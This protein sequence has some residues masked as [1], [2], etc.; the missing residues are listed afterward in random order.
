[1]NFVKLPT[2]YK[3]LEYIESNGTQWIN[4]GIVP[5]KNTKVIMDFQL[6]N[7]DSTN[8]CI[9]GVPGQYS[10]RWYGPSS[11]FRANGSNSKNFPTSIDSN[12]RHIVEQTGTTS[13]I[14]NTYSVTI[15]AATSIKRKLGIFAM[16]QAKTAQFADVRLYSMQIY[17][18]E[19][20]VRDFV[21][22]KNSLGEV[23]LY[24][25]VDNVFYSNS[26]TGTFI[27]GPVLPNSNV[28]IK[29]N[30][31]WNIGQS[32]VKIDGDWKFVTNIIKL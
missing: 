19:T 23:G 2:G 32:Y 13:T 3:L 10:F 21:P 5:D 31:I 12:V 30:D 17:S 14:D 29:V 26:G 25:S 22:C 1:M 28:L 4:T 15:T 9:F 7:P 18:S 24:D 8:Q 11:F 6:T 20:M 27:A 16:N